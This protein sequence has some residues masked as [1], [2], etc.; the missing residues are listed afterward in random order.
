MTFALAS[1]TIFSAQPY[2][3]PPMAIGFT[4][5]PAIIAISLAQPIAGIFSDRLSQRLTKLNHGTY[6][7]EFRLLGMIPASIFSTIG[8]LGFGITVHLQ[9]QQSLTKPPALWIPLLWYAVIAFSV[10]FTNVAAFSYLIDSHQQ[11]ANEAFV[12]VH[13]SKAVL[14]LVAA[15]TINGWILKSGVKSVF[16]VIACV[17]LAV[18]FGSLV[19]WI[20]GK[21]MRKWVSL[22]AWSKKI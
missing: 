15:G 16:I 4:A 17:N 2:F 21:S 22:Q 19:F 5:V 6:E 11:V 8:F 20:Y 1:I 18:S 13:F 7:P 10:P 9:Q 14:L 3:L 12:T